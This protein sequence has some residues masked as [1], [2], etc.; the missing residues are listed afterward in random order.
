MRLW[1]R[2]LWA[3]VSILTLLVLSTTT[4]AANDIQGSDM[5]RIGGDVTVDEG[6]VVKDAVAI[7]GSVTVLSC[8]RVMKNAVAIGG[9]VTLK[10]N[11]HVEGDTVAIG[12]EILKEEGASVGRNEVAILSGAKQLLPAFWKWSLLDIL[13]GSYLASLVLH[14]LVALVIAGL[15]ILLLLFVPGPLQIISSTMRQSAFKSV[16]WGVGSFVVIVLLLIF[17]TGSLLGIVLAPVL[18]VAIAVVG[19]LGCVATGLFIGERTFS[20]SAGSLIRPFL[21]G[22]LILAAMGL[23]PLVGELVFLVANLFGFGAVL[24]SR[25]GRVPPVAAGSL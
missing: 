21:V 5:V 20:P 14:I 6:R 10:A 18:V 16:G 7:G 13:Y 8:G 23:V 2:S 17:T 9:D 25:F 11:A 15:G 24:L 22:M 3:L 19:I 4:F 12:G 1:R